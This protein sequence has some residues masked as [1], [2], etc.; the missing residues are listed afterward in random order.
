MMYFLLILFFGSLVGITFM[1][2][3]KLVLLKNGEV[4]YHHD[5]EEFFKDFFKSLKH[6]SVKYFK[7]YGYIGLVATVRLY[8]HLANFL[9]RKYQETKIKFKEIYQRKVK[10]EVV[11]KREVSGFLKL[12]SE[13]KHKIRKIRRQIKEE[14]NL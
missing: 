9:K 11:E 10:K 13:Y 8:V 6:E 3:K 4:I 7:K 12:I 1:V 5:A 14:E 2:G